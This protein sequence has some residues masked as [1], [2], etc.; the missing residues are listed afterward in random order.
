[1]S[2]CFLLLAASSYYS[3]QITPSTVAFVHIHGWMPISLHPSFFSVVIAWCVTQTVHRAHCRPRP[4]HVRSCLAEREGGR[5][6]PPRPKCGHDSEYLLQYCTTP[7]PQKQKH[8]V[9]SLPATTIPFDAC[10]LQRRPPPPPPPPGRGPSRLTATRL[11][12]A[13][14]AHSCPSRSASACAVRASSVA[15]PATSSCSCSAIVNDS[16]SVQAERETARRRSGPAVA[17]ARH[18][19]LHC[20]ALPRILWLPDTPAG[21]HVS[22]GSGT[23]LPAA[24][25]VPSVPT[26]PPGAGALPRTFRSLPATR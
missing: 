18:V 25:C 7:V 5:D 14:V 19:S 15:R 13:P 21:S 10:R 12:P 3:S 11:A 4:S 9:Q 16:P 24:G 26:L 22:A 20:I 23:V 8:V 1:M 2:P 17:R 6:P